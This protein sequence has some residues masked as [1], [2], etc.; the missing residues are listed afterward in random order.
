[1]GRWLFLIHHLALCHT[2]QRMSPWA[3]ICWTCYHQHSAQGE[4]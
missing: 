1:M 2:V 3:S 4:S